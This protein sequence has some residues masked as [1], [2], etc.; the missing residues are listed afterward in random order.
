M[1]SENSEYLKNVKLLIRLLLVSTLLSVFTGCATIVKGT[2]QTIPVSSDPSGADVKLDGLLY[3][4]TPTTLEVKRKRNHLIVIEKAGYQPKS[5]PITK[6][7]GGA[8]WGNILAG[9]LI[10]WGVDA[11]SGAQYNLTP[12]VVTVKLELASTDNQKSESNANNSEFVTKLNQLDGLVEGKTI[13]KDNYV[14]ERCK[15]FKEYFPSIKP[16]ESCTKELK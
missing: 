4:Q 12:E 14:T 9:G 5:V 1:I 11:T 16:E 8:V 13:T 6:N 15:L 7:V 2:T 10:G 3:G